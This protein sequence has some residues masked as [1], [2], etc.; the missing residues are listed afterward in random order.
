MSGNK[1]CLHPVGKRGTAIE[2]RA[3]RIGHIDDAQP[4]HGDAERH[5]CSRH[6]AAVQP[7]VR[8]DA[9]VCH[10][11]VGH[12]QHAGTGVLELE[13]LVGEL[14]AGRPQRDMGSRR[15]DA[16]VARTLERTVN[17]MLLRSGSW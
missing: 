14:L 17:D 10:H 5:E 8:K 16:S 3:E 9:D 6:G 13:I 4:E 2:H 11:G 12:A 7:C 15:A 1:T